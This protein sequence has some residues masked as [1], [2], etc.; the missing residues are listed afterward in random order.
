MT[1]RKFVD[2]E[3]D[4]IIYDYY[5]FNNQSPNEIIESMNEFNENYPGRDLYFSLFT[6]G[7]DI[8]V[9]VHERRLEND[10]EYND[11][12]KREE[13][14]NNKAKSNEDNERAEYLRLKAKFESK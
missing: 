5:V 2:V 14:V 4:D 12:I 13:R 10:N 9:A 1:D 6:S 11:R 8:E 7:G 3:C